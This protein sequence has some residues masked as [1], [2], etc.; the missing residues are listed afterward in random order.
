MPAVY[1]LSPWRS[2]VGKADGGWHGD[3]FS[4]KLGI[5]HSYGLLHTHT[6]IFEAKFD[7][8]RKSAKLHVGI[9]VFAH[10][11]GDKIDF[12]FSSL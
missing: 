4:T 1:E 6:L 8:K 5:Y 3:D 10:D 12:L 9:I 11:Q 2:P 7:L